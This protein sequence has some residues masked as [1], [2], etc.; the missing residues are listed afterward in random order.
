MGG[1]KAFREKSGATLGK[2][3]WS[4]IDNEGYES[5]KERVR[6]LADAA[7]NLKKYDETFYHKHRGGTIEQLKRMEKKKLKPLLTE[8]QYIK[9]SYNAT[10][11]DYQYELFLKEVKPTLNEA[12]DIIRRVK[13]F[14]EN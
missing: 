11:D 2:T 4:E 10:L 12:E 13:W 5:I 7:N 14:V 6:K 8:L 9:N 1:S 3:P